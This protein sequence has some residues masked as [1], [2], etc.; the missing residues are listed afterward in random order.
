M[1]VCV[2]V[3]VLVTVLV[4]VLTLVLGVVVVVVVGGS[5]VVVVGGAVVVVGVSVTVWV[6]SVGAGA[7]G[8][9]MDGD[10]EVVEEVVVDVVLEELPPASLTMAKTISAIR[11]TASAPRATRAAGFRYQGVGGSTGGPGGC[12]L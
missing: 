12:W 3:L 4:L 6:P 7:T 10:V 8:W 1:I 9:D 5:V 11:M 2:L